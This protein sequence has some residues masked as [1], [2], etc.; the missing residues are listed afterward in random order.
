VQSRDE[1]QEQRQL[2]GLQTHG[3][4]HDAPVLGVV[5]EDLTK[6]SAEG[7]RFSAHRKHR[8][9]NDHRRG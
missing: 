2:H 3:D 7:G 1:Q 4:G 6:R 5:G 8:V 9:L